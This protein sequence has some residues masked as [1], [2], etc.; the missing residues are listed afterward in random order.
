[1][2]NPTAPRD[3][4]HGKC[5]L[6]C[7]QALPQTKGKK[8]PTTI[9]Q[10]LAKSCQS[11]GPA[12]GER[13]SRGRRGAA[14][15][16]RVPT[17]GAAGG[18]GAAPRG[19]PAPQPPAPRPHRQQGAAAAAVSRP[20]PRRPSSLASLLS[21]IPHP[22]I[23]ESSR[24]LIPQPASRIPAFHPTSCVLA[25]R[26]ALTPSSCVQ[27]RTSPAGQQSCSAA[28]SP[29]L[30]TWQPKLLHILAKDMK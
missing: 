2:S 6:L 10:H 28:S 23:P 18:A 21:R 22:R 24:P 25:S 15:Q 11:R 5:A 13:L 4:S 30:G 8:K 20:P 29:T 17:R 19:A 9:R 3:S 12:G 27:P 16:Q 1:M 14:P 26:D 7:R